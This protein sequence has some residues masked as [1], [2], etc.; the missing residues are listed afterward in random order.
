MTLRRFAH[1]SRVAAGGEDEQPYLAAPVSGT[2]LVPVYPKTSA[3]TASHW[4]A[5]ATTLA[6]AERALYTA[7][8]A[9]AAVRAGLHQVR[10][11]PPRF[12]T[13]T[14]SCV[15][16]TARDDVHTQVGAAPYRWIA[17]RSKRQAIPAATSP[18]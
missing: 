3:Y 1:L 7:G 8:A 13:R 6:E 15:W 18:P 12:E 2:R 14:V 10:A 16:I 4:A 5:A 11:T 9:G 17:W